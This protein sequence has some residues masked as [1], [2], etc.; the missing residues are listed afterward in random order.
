M[1]LGERFWM[2]VEVSV[3]GGLLSGVGARIGLLLTA[4]GWP[5]MALKGA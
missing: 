3:G 2:N 4:S 1:G 5:W